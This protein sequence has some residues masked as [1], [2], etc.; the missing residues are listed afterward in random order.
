MWAARSAEEEVSQTACDVY[1][2]QVQEKPADRTPE[3]QILQFGIAAL[4]DRLAARQEAAPRPA[5]IPER[6]PVPEVRSVQAAQ[7]PSPGF[8][9]RA[10][11]A[12]FGGEG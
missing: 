4:K 5:V 2:R 1:K 12:L 10:V 3:I 6:T 7:P 8:F 9:G 11:R